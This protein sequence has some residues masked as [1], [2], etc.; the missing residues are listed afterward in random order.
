MTVLG[1]DGREPGPL[2]AVHGLLTV[3]A[4]LV[5]EALGRRAQELRCTD[6]V[7][8][9]HMWDL[10][11]REQTCIPCIGRQLLMTS[12]EVPKLYLLF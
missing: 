6:L 3:T 9:R 10:L 7:V 12:R 11:I 4:S 2:P 1:L 5:V 8:L